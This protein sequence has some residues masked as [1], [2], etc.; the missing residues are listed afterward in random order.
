MLSE[1]AANTGPNLMIYIFYLTWDEHAHHY[2][3]Y[4][5]FQEIWELHLY[6]ILYNI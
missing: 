2:A 6:L 5:V 1:E 3:T 4:S